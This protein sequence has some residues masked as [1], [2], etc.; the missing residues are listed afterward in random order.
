LSAALAFFIVQHL[1]FIIRRFLFTGQKPPILYFLLLHPRS[2]RTPAGVKIFSSPTKT[3][4]IA[5]SQFRKQLRIEPI[6]FSL[7][8]PPWKY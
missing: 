7:A 1:S 4:P 8:S 2:L 5:A 3:A 6:G